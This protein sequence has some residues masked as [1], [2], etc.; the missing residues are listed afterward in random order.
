M[1]IVSSSDDKTIYILRCH[2][3]EFKN[4]SPSRE[5]Y[6]VSSDIDKCIEALKLDLQDMEDERDD[7]LFLY[8]IDALV[9][10]SDPF[11]HPTMEVFRFDWY[12]NE[13][14][15]GSTPDYWFGWD[16]VALVG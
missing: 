3:T 14:A 9:P 6:Y 16:K 13:I 12:G 1:N 15:I 8:T 5:I 4:I 10:D 2:E 11:T 7:I